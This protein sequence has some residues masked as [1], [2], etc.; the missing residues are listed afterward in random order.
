MPDRLIGVWQTAAFNLSATSPRTP[1]VREIKP[2][3]ITIY[4]G[5]AAVS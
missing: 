3:P 1:S 2:W 4:I 5:E